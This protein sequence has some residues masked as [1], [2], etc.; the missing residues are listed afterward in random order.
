MLDNLYK[1]IVS[2]PELETIYKTNINKEIGN[3]L[4]TYFY[5]LG[6]IKSIFLSKKNHCHIVHLHQFHLNINL[7]ITVTICKFFFKKLILTVH[8]VESFGGKKNRSNSIAQE[9]A[10]HVRL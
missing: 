1:S 4:S 6:L 10:P 2:I 5:Y 8:D 3:Y 7:L 9:S